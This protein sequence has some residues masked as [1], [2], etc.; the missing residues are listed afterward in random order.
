MKFYWLRRVWYKINPKHKDRL[1]CKIFG[2]EKYKRYALELYNAVN[3]S[4]YTD[5]SDLEIITLDDAVYIKM[6]NDV[7]YLISG[8]IAL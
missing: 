6:K 7:A 1:F 4:S 5:L 3:G 8:N 2:R